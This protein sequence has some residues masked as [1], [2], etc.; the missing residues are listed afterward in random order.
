MLKS[1]LTILFAQ[2]S[3]CA[4]A[5]SDTTIIKAHLNAL[6]K[7]ERSR[8]YYN[9]RQLDQTAAYIE[10]IFNQYADTVWIQEYL[11]N[12]NTYR[13]VVC[14]FGVNQKK[15]IVI[16]AHY[17][18]CGEQEGA[19]DNASGVVGL[20]ELAR[21]L[22][23]QHL[24]YR[25]DLVAYSLEEPPY[26][27]T[28]YMGSYIH[29]QSLAGS[30]VDV[31]GMICFDMI[32]YFSSE[33]KSQAYPF[34]I[35]SLFYGKKGNYITLIK[36]FGG[37]SFARRFARRYK[38]SATIRAKKF[39]APGKAPGVSYS[40][41]ANYWNLDYSAVLI[42]DTSIFRNRN[43]HLPSDTME[44]LDIKSMAQVIDGVMVTLRKM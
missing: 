37:G 19:D 40:D 33:K 5:N 31:Y 43:Y 24:P 42:T 14:S 22:H 6:T 32:G 1:I 15:R 35:L 34:G 30:N 25:I 2:V 41:H 17:D 7:T 4:L 26:F 38:S 28:Q 39:S 11:A 44:T 27:R 21:L 9:V 3:V 29:A 36:R 23:G 16:G 18:V 13:N 10:N 8:T 12:G 20:L